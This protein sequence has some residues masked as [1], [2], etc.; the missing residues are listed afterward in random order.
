MP[1]AGITREE[2]AV[3]IYRC[4]SSEV[5]LTGEPLQFTD[6]SEISQYALEAVAALSGQ[7]IISGMGNGCFEPRGV[8]TRAQAAV[9][10]CSALDFTA[11][12][13]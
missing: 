6:S 5:N 7:G 4:I 2:A 9:L 3:M 11:A 12:Q 1:D 8:T 13:K 10:V